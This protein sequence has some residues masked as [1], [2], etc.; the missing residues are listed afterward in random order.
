MIRPLEAALG[1]ICQCGEAL[2]HSVFVGGLLCY[3]GL[4]AAAKG[5][6]GS[7][8]CGESHSGVC[9]LGPSAVEPAEDPTITL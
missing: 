6:S 4:G 1:N 8:K 3:F 9:L 7:E 2:T 5:Q